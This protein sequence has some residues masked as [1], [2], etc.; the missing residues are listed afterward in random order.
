MPNIGKEEFLKLSKVERLAAMKDGRFTVPNDGTPES[1]EF[2]KLMFQDPAS[3][4]PPS[5]EPKKEEPVP[6]TPEPK[7]TEPPAPP[8][9]PPKDFGGYPTMEEFVKAHEAQKT[10]LQ[11]QT[12]I[13]DKINATNGTQGRKLKSLETQLAEVN[14]QIE[15]QK[16]E[17][18]PEQEI[19]IPDRPN[20]KD[21]EDGTL[22]PKYQQALDAYTAKLEEA[23]KTALSLSKANRELRQDVEKVKSDLNETRSFIDED[24]LSKS[25]SVEQTAWDGLSQSLSE[26]QAE[27][28][29]QMSVPW[30]QING[31]LLVMKDESAPQ[32]ARTAA[33]AWINALPPTDIEAFKKLTPVVTTYA[34]FSTGVPRPKFQSMK[35]NGFRGSLMD[36]G[37]VFQKPPAQRAPAPQPP[38]PGVTPLPAS[39]TSSDEPKLSDLQTGQEKQHRLR[40]L[41]SMRKQNPKGFQ[42]K[43]EL[44]KEFNDLRVFFGSTPVRA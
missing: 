8:A 5:P 32:E 36:Q 24:R 31:K 11:R 42:G 28:G 14:K 39:A 4:T 23:A 30:T 1:E 3:T 34:D 26:F 43:A 22:D 33:Q 37:F 10:L 16:K 20:L 15:E 13:I 29:I 27:T 17:V 40:E 7:P 41:D 18:Q 12:D 6:P 25:K 9:E 2:R 19:V 44:L 21:F 38:A 35:S